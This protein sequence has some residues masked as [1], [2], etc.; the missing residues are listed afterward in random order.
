MVARLHGEGGDNEL[1]PQTRAARDAGTCT[2]KAAEMGGAV[3]PGQPLGVGGPM[4]DLLMAPLGIRS[5]YSA[6][7]RGEGGVV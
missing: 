4:G 2:D 7:I 1:R 3:V 5:V 6:P